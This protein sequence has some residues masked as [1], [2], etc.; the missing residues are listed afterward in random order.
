MEFVVIFLWF[1][2]K[3]LFFVAVGMVAFSVRVVAVGLKVIDPN[4]TLLY[5]F[6]NLLFLMIQV[7]GV[8]NLEPTLQDRL[9]LFVFGGQGSEYIYDYAAR[10]NV[11]ECRIAKAIW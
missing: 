4:I 3:V 9:Y 11:Y 5:K 2:V 7:L 1:I 10:K 8:V 6:L